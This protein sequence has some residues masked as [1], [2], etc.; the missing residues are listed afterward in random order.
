MNLDVLFAEMLVAFQNKDWGYGE[1]LGS[2]TE[3]S[4]TEVRTHFRI[5]A[6]ATSETFR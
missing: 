2:R 1:F 6:S 5:S 3:T 4:Y